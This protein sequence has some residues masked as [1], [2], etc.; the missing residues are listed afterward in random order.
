M[1]KKEKRRNQI[2][3]Q[4]MTMCKLEYRSGDNLFKQCIGLIFI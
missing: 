3:I 4:V 1:K 2:Q